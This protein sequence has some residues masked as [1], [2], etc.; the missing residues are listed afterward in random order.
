M[1][2]DLTLGYSRDSDVPTGQYV[3]TFAGFDPSNGLG[4]FTNAVDPAD[5]LVKNFPRTPITGSPWRHWSSME[6]PPYLD[7]D[8]KSATAQF[9]AKIG[10]S[11]EFV[12]ITNWMQMHKFYIEDSAGGFGFFPY[13]TVN[14]YDQ[15]SQEFRLSG[16]ERQDALAG[17][18]LLP[19]HDLGYVPVRRWRGRSSAARQRQ[20]QMMS[21]FGKV[22]SRN[23]SVFGQV[24]YDIDRSWTLI[25]RRS[26]VA[27]RQGPRDE[28]RL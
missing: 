3:V 18:R 8:V 24:E 25:A 14:D 28:P 11:A 13:N 9:T 1:L 22:D 17:G 26:L 27:G 15:F 19:R 5:G 4:A 20:R 10:G 7:R 16:V 21:T 23:W 12:S 2:F 6:P